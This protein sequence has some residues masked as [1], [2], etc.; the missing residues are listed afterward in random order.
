M[1]ENETNPEATSNPMSEGSPPPAPPAAQA[2]G[3]AGSNTGNEGAGP[4]ESPNSAGGDAAAGGEQQGRGERRRKGKRD[5]GKGGG[6]GPGGQGGPGRPQNQ[7]HPRDGGHGGGHRY[8][9]DRIDIDAE[10][11]ARETRY[12]TADRIRPIAFLTAQVR[13]LLGSPDS[14]DRREAR[15][16]LVLFKSRVAFMA[17]RETGRERSGFVKIRD[18]ML[19]GIEQVTRDRETLDPLQVRNFL[20]Q[21][22]AYVGYHRFHCDDRR[23]D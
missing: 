14:H 23:R 17:G 18:F 8:V 4:G 10:Q 12:I 11:L 5:R 20:D 21:V 19:R 7:G 13:R 6:H 15:R 3:E 1:N 16:C 9:E 22:D 2:P